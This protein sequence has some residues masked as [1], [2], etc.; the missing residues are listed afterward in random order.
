VL[1]APDR[2]CG[3]GAVSPSEKGA[4]VYAGWRNRLP[5]RSSWGAA[6]AVGRGSSAMGWLN[7]ELSTVDV[8]IRRSFRGC[9]G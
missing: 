5:Y 3:A 7:S 8:V 9:H 1:A 4:G 2:C 6:N